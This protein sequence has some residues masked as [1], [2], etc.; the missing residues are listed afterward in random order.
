MKKILLVDNSSLILNLL[1][2]FFDKSVQFELFKTNSIK[3]AKELIEKE[4][5]FLAVSSVVLTDG[6]KGE[7]IN[8]LF[9]KS[10]PTIIL[11]SIIDDDVITIAHKYSV[12]DYVSKNSINDLE[13][14]YTLAKLLVFIE[15]TEILIVDDSP[16]SIEMVKSL[17][18]TLLL[19]V[20]SA[21]SGQEA[22]SLL[23][24]NNN[25]SLIISD[26]NMKEIDGLE[27]V[28]QLRKNNHYLRTPIIIMAAKVS[29]NLKID[30][31]KNG[32]ADCLI[33]PIL[34]EE[35][36]AKILNIFSNEKYIS[37]IKKFHGI[38]NQNV[39]TISMDQYGVINSISETFC[40]ISEYNKNEI[41]GKRY[42]ILI[43]PDIPN[44][45][46]QEIWA[47]VSV[48]KKWQGEVKNIKKHGGFYWV[49]MII[50][51]N[52]DNT[53]M[54]IGHTVI[55][56]DITDKKR[57]Y[58]LSITDGLTS[59]YNKRHFHDMS[60][61][62]LKNN[63]RNNKNFVF[64]LLDIDNFKKYND[65]YGHQAGD[66]VLAKIAKSLKKS[67]KRNDDMVFRLGGEE[68]GVIFS[69]KDNED[70]ISLAQNARKNIENLE[71]EHKENKPYLKVTS[72]F[73]LT[74]LNKKSDVDDLDIEAIYKLSDFYLYKAKDAGRNRVE[75][76]K[77]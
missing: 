42:D 7:M 57:I 74:I 27:F 8:Y 54:I 55:A 76:K 48:G 3:E 52:F 65:T 43:H 5:F 14:I 31:Y 69:T 41:I 70:A 49:K 44:S 21:Q 1:S 50:E 18:Q 40:D 11:T 56:Q 22:L 25:I 67:F 39:L 58:E 26:Y 23:E 59:L 68:F 75:Y 73:G 38:I 72:S 6:E 30:F 35:L 71:I 17:M 36:K 29:N 13:H 53:G 10:I 66:E 34:P 12:I 15:G 24:S 62:L 37:D 19:K 33:K 51:P 9:E 28:Q 47:N 45:L 46:H 63:L 64:L 32:V 16:V 2:D 20:H 4:D 61:V 60:D 77:D